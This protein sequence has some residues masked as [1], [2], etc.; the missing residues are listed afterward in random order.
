MRWKCGES[1]TGRLHMETLQDYVGRVVRVFGM[2]ILH[3]KLNFGKEKVIYFRHPL[4]HAQMGKRKCNY[5]YCKDLTFNSLNH[6]Y[7][8]MDADT[9]PK[10]KARARKG[11]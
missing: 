10:H 4:P 3:T 7:N 1:L 9:T 11:K 8:P 5:Y 6:Y 2:I